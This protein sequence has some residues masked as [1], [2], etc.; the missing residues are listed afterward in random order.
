MAKISL[1]FAKGLAIVNDIA[2]FGLSRFE[3]KREGR[4]NINVVMFAVNL[5]TGEVIFQRPLPPDCGLVNEITVP[6][7]SET[8]SWKEVKTEL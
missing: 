4:M 2:Y 5:N 3:T 7:L 8:S 1:F 6:S